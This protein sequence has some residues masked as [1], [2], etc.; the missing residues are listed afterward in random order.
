MLFKLIILFTVIPIA[1]LA[2]L[3]KLNN[4]IGL[5]YTLL[6][7]FLTGIIGATLAKSEGK[8]IIKRIKFEGSQGKMPGDELINGL[9]VLIGGAFLLTPGLLTDIAGFSLVI[10]FTRFAIKSFIKKQLKQMI[11]EG[12]FSIYYRK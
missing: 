10:P 12:N 8:G 11:Q 1:E 3:L 5:P 2:I 7:V 6:L 4:Y 9:C